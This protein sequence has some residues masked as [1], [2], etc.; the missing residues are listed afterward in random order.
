LESKINT[1]EEKRASIR[2]KC[3]DTLGQANAHEVEIKR[4]IGEKACI[5]TR[6]ELA[7][8]AIKKQ[9]ADLVI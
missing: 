9:K 3:L 1:E 5:N 7:K 2:G 6:L 4:L 8:N